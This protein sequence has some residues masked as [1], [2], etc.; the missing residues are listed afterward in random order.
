[1]RQIAILNNYQRNLNTLEYS[2]LIEEQN[3]ASWAVVTWTSCTVIFLCIHFQRGNAQ[4]LETHLWWQNAM[5]TA[6]Q[7]RCT[8]TLRIAPVTMWA[9][10]QVGEQQRFTIAQIHRVIIS[11]VACSTAKL[12]LRRHWMYAWLLPTI[13]W[14]TVSV[15]VSRQIN[16]FLH[17]NS[18]HFAR[19]DKSVRQGQNPN[20]F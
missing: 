8:P 19:G 10:T 18:S 5:E 1:M 14:W 4:K 7:S 16:G 20:R 2:E 3:L 6:E 11:S 17:H 9:L 15:L 13:P 12:S